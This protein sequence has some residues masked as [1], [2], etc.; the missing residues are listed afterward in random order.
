MGQEN[1]TGFNC[2]LFEKDNR[3]EVRGDQAMKIRK[4]LEQ[5]RVRYETPSHDNEPFGPVVLPNPKKRAPI[6]PQP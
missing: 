5:E 1:S 6:R 3:T 2:G 4:M